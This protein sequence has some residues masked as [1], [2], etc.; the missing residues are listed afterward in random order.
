[1]TSINNIEQGITQVCDLTELDPRYI[2]FKMKLPMYL[3]QMESY[4][5][6]NNG[7]LEVGDIEGVDVVLINATN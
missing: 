2:I 3:Q 7:L 4:G 5:H 1:M 6:Y